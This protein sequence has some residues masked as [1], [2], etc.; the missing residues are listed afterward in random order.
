[1]KKLLLSLLLGFS[2]NVFATP[3]NVNTADA[4]TIAASLSGVG[5]K[6]AEAIVADRTKN[7]LFKSVDDLKRVSGIGEKTVAANRNDILLADPAP[8]TTTPASPATST[9]PAAAPTPAPAAPATPAA[10]AKAPEA[11]K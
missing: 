2:V 5:L 9:T 4:K 1:M 6:K 3:V 7:G 10:P 11:K 8:A